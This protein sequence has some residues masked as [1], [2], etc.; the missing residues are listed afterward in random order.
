M[1]GRHLSRSIVVQSLCEWDFKNKD[2]NMLKEIIEH[3]LAR[4]NHELEARKF[5][6]SLIDGIIKDRKSVV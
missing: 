6:Y 1:S 2:K 5:I 3:N 4:F